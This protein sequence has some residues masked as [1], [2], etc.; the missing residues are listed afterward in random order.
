MLAPS[1]TKPVCLQF[2]PL[3]ALKPEKATSSSSPAASSYGCV[4]RSCPVHFDCRYFLF[5]IDL[6]GPILALF[7]GHFLGGTDSYLQNSC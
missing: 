6:E 1:F 5:Q 2:A 3:Q 4:I 7:Q